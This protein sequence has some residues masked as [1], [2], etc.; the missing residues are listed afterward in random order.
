M[1]YKE[2]GNVHLDFHRT[3]N[4]T[5]SYLRANYGRKFLDET[6]RRTAR[7]VYAAIREDLKQGNPEH[8]VEHW[9]Y[10]FDREG[11]QYTLERAD[12]EIRFIVHRCPAVAYLQGRGIPIDEDFCCQ[13]VV[14]NNALA[15]GTPFEVSTEVLGDGK[16]M[17]T[18]RRRA[19]P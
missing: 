12:D 3:T 16:C 13:T 17:Q 11:G 4:G 18:I 5:I 8:L 7:D 10:F 2:T 15:E 19:R 9:T 6:F 1:R 14:V